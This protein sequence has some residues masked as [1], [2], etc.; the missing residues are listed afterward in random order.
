MRV[1][2]LRHASTARWSCVSAIWEGSNV[3]S[4]THELARL[5]VV[6]KGDFTFG[7]F[8]FE[9]SVVVMYYCRFIVVLR[10]Q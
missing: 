7:F 1:D 2:F 5:G 3:D 4:P 9:V 10:R 8:R 6:E